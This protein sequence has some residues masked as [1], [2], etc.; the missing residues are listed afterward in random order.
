MKILYVNVAA[1]A[2]PN[3]FSLSN[4]MRHLVISVADFREALKLI[5]VE[6]FDAV[7]IDEGEMHPGTID[8]MSTARRLRP[9]LPICVASAWGEH[10]PMVLQTLERL[11][12][13]V[14]VY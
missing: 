6:P 12:S 13:P 2:E 1:D 9:E 14:E 5:E 11:A 8:F 4:D 3:L 10:L 7:V